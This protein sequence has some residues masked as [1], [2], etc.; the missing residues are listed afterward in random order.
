MTKIQFECIHHNQIPVFDTTRERCNIIFDTSKNA[1][2]HETMFKN[3]V[4]IIKIRMLSSDDYMT[5]KP[6]DEN[7]ILK[8]AE[9][10]K[11]PIISSLRNLCLNDQN[12]YY[13]LKFI[14]KL[15]QLVQENRFTFKDIKDAELYRFISKELIYVC[16]LKGEIVLDVYNLYLLKT[17][18]LEDKKMAKS[19]MFIIKN[20]LFKSLKKNDKSENHF[21]IKKCENDFCTLTKYQHVFSNTINDED[22]FHNIFCTNSTPIKQLNEFI[23]F[24]Q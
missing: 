7:L 2:Y 24:L 13:V 23:N 4:G 6:N 3:G 12:I 22:F 8:Y 15:F 20:L 10:I 14:I 11:S 9:Q 17:G 16:V 5:S 18:I 19:A 1:W 21:Q